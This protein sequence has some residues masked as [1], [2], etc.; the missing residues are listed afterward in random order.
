[1]SL[2]SPTSLANPTSL[3][4]EGARPGASSRSLAALRDEWHAAAAL[5]VV[6]GA[7]VFNPLLCFVNTNGLRVSD[8]MVM[9]SE[10]ILIS[11]ALCFAFGRSAAPY[12]ILATFLAYMIMLMAMRPLIDP[13]AVRDLLIPL[14]FYFM[15]RRLGDIRI[16]DKAA[17]ICGII[18]VLFG[19]FEYL[20]FD[21]FTKYFNVIQYYI[22]RG[23]VNPAALS[24][25]ES[26]L[27][28]SGMRPDA[29]NILPFLGPHRVSSVFLEPVSM[30]NFGAILA[31]WALCRKGMHG[32]WVAF[33]CGAIAIILAD[34]RFGLYVC[35]LGSAV[36]FSPLR[37]HRLFWLLLPFAM[38][39]GIALY[40]Y[41]IGNIP[42][43]NDFGG[44]L[45]WTS[46]LVTSLDVRAVMGLSPDKPF[47]SDSGYAY[48]LN[49]IGLLA[50]IA[51][52]TLFI[53]APLRHRQAWL[54]RMCA[55]AYFCLLLVISD[56]PYSIKTAALLWFMLGSADAMPAEEEAASSAG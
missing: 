3:A 48:S 32:R 37:P 16:A 23:T 8:V 56:S 22:A 13:K 4:L 46:Q 26:S 19:L 6:I 12:L 52:W 11:T 39:F 44:R 40:G 10:L 35:I 36:I 53:L 54:F 14:A 51:F 55:A 17:L 43:T 27:F 50:C 29:R 34:A 30:G 49:Q 2:A 47:L 38:L 42:W 41:R 9:G 45:I 5:F 7:L 33:A 18:V 25:Q 31:L 21:L 20:A 1:M 28:V 24:P 15:A